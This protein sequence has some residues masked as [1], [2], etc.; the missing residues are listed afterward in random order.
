[1]RVVPPLA[2]LSTYLREQAVQSLLSLGSQKTVRTRSSCVVS[3]TSTAAMQ[4]ARTSSVL[5]LFA[6]SVQPAGISLGLVTSS[7]GYLTEPVS[8]AVV[9]RS[10]TQYLSATQFRLQ[11]TLLFP[12]EKHPALSKSKC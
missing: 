9:S 3:T 7:F 11:N 4:A 8:C 10:V 6:V 5:R 1:M 2:R 12:V